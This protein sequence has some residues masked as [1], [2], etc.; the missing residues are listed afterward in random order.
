[1][2]DRFSLARAGSVA[3]TLLLASCGGGGGSGDVVPGTPAVQAASGGPDSFLLFPNPQKLS[4]GSLETN[5]T[6]YAEAYY[7]AI[8]PTNTKDTLAKWKAANNFDSGTGAQVGAVFGDVR[9]LGYGRRMTARQNADGTVA[10]MVENYQVNAGGAYGYNSLNLDAA[11]VTDTRWHVGTNAIEFSPGPNGGASFAKFYT[12]N[13]TTGERLLMANLDARGNKAM[14]GICINCHGGRADPL[15]PADGGGKPLFPLVQNSVSQHRGDVQARLHML[16]ADHLEFSTMAGFTRPELEATVK[17]INKMILCT[18]PLPAPSAA[19]ED[20]CRPTAGVNEWQGTAAAVLKAAYGGDGLPNATFAD[21]Y[22]PPAWV[23]AGRTSLYNDVAKQACMTCHI[24][25]GT[26]NQSD[27]DFTSYAKFAG[28]SD[29]I[30]AHVYDRGNMPLAKIVA[31]RFWSTSM[32]ETMGSWLQSL[33]LTVRDSSST[34][35]RPGRPI[36]DPGPS[37][38]VTFGPTTLSAAGSLYADS[39]NWSIVA[40]PGNA[41]TLTNAAS[42]TPTFTATANGTYVLQ[43]V[44]SN[45]TTQSTPAA[46]T[47]V[48]NNALTPAPSAIRFADIKAV[49]QTPGACLTCHTPP[50]TAAVKPPIFYSDTD[51]NGDGLINATDTSWMYKEVRGRVNFTDIVASPLLRKPSNNHHNGGLQTGFDTSLPPGDP[52]RANYDLFVNWIMN[53]APE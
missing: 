13:P 44:A 10:I 42:A 17:T 43:L 51:R 50:G 40:N 24:L 45:S 1:V 16:N 29:R 25:R 20:A 33:G 19:P 22:V 35:L 7:A 28:Y 38:T 15:T 9:D 53:G 8:D 12:F 30:K 27:L 18:Y 32:A 36:A 3:L 23:S 49:L 46:L 6:A 37:R 31:D 34:L 5:T 2:N 48:V 26:N 4:D 39:Y 52:G 11:V 21:T 14:P 41:G 47:L